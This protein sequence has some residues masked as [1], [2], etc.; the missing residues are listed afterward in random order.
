MTSPLRCVSGGSNSHVPLVSYQSREET[1]NV[2]SPDVFLAAIL[3]G[4]CEG[5][6]AGTD[7]EVRDAL[8]CFYR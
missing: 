7:Q 5:D 6:P 3:K 8:D 1:M 2:E 4:A